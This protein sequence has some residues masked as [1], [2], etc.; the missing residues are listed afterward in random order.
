M[1]FPK[2]SLEGTLKSLGGQRFGHPCSKCN[3][4]SKSN[5]H[6]CLLLL[7]NIAVLYHIFCGLGILGGLRVVIDR[8]TCGPLLALAGFIGG[9]VV[10][11]ND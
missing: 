10:I 4:I 2:K 9:Y 8:N 5:L 3:L 6:L 7:L 11:T 1:Q